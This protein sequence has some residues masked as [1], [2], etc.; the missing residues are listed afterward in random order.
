MGKT[1]IKARLVAKCFQE[2]DKTQSDSPT[3]L[4][5]N[6]KIFYAV[7]ANE[8]FDLAS[9][10]IRAAFLQSNDLDR[11]VFMKPPSDLIVEGR[12]WRLKKLS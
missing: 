3:V 6:S 5:E 10:D 12:V 7:A 11:D 8:E 2:T 4:K 9:K 1:V